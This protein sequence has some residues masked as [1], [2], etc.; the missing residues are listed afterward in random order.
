MRRLD[1]LK[2]LF[3]LPS[4][5]FMVMNVRAQSQSATDSTAENEEIYRSK[6][7]QQLLSESLPDRNEFS[8]W[9]GFALDSFQLWGKTQDVHIQ[10]LGFRYNRKLIR[11]YNTML[12]YNLLVNLYSNYS[13]Q[14]FEPYNYRNSLSGLG[15]SPLGLQLNFFST[16]TFQPFINTSTGL[17]LMD[18][19]FP[20][21]RGKK[22]NFTFDAGGGVEIMLLPSLSFSLGVKYHHLSNGERGQINPG[23]DSYFYYTSITIF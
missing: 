8:V 10:S 9:I 7:Q 6:I 2:I 15:I 4:L 13:Y 18:K 19:P 11:Y 1:H 21:D 3:L 16:R 23:V 14:G 5:F 12:E 20:D 17:M 22:L